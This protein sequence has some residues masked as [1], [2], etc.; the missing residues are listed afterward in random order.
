[1]ALVCSL[2]SLLLAGTPLS[3][4]ALPIT[5]QDDRVLLHGTDASVASSMEQI[6][7]L[8]FNYV[9]LTAGWSALSPHPT[10]PRIPRAP[11]NPANAATYPYGGFHELDR[12]VLDAEQDGLKVMIDVAFW[13]PRWAVPLGSPDGENRY[14]PNPTLFGEFAHAVA[15]R[16]DGATPYPADPSVTLPAVQLYTVWNEPNESEFLQPQWQKTPSGWVAASPNVYRNMYVD[17]YGQIKGVT[18]ADEVLMGAT[19]AD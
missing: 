5:I 14:E 11:F 4:H 15:Q 10:S 8:G 3:Q 17:A 9:R 19:S 12:A 2:V 13:A 1:M 6:A 18:P 16:Y 7:S